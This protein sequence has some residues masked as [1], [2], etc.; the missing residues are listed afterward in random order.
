MRVSLNLRARFQEQG[1]TLSQDASV[2]GSENN[3]QLIDG[4]TIYLIRGEGNQLSV[5]L[6]AGSAP[7]N[8]GASS[9]GVRNFLSRVYYELRNRGATPQKRAINYSATNALQVHDVFARA[10]QSS[11]ELEHISVE[12]S[13]IYRGGSDCWDVKLTF[14]HPQ[15]RLRL[16]KKA[17]RFTVDVSDVIPVTVGGRCPSLVDVR[18]LSGRCH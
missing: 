16:A 2:M 13:A 12:R 10:I 3:W 9:S 8:I 11:F 18:K 5:Y 7:D 17:Y 4:D 1:L 14:F 6:Q 15:Q